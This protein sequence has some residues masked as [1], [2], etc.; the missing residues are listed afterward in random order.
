V[1]DT[2]ENKN[3]VE[4]IFIGFSNDP[5]ISRYY[6]KQQK[7]PFNIYYD[8]TKYFL[9]E[10]KLMENNYTFLVNTNNMVLFEGNPFI[11]HKILDVYINKINEH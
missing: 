1:L 7:L 11:D 2:L 9:K 10:N 8:S 5:S 6:L 4:I 3:F